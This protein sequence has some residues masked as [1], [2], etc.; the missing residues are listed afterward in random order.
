VE[1]VARGHGLILQFMNIILTPVVLANLRAFFGEFAR[2]A[3]GR[4]G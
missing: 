1:E 2:A 4:S 3:G